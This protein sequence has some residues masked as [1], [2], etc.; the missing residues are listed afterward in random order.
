M[1][2]LTFESIPTTVDVAVEQPAA[3]Q[4]VRRQELAPADPMMEML[5]SAV[6]TGNVELVKELYA[7][8]KQVEAD[9][10]KKAFAEAFSRFKAEA[11]VIVKNVT[12]TDG[13]LKGKKHA[14]NYG[15]C[16]AV[17]PAL[18]KYGLSH[19]WKLTK[20]EPGWMEVTCTIRHVTGY[21]E[22]VSMGGAPDTGPGRNAIQARGSTKTYLERYTLLA[23][24][25]LAAQDDNDGV[26]SGKSQG[27]SDEDF[28]TRKTA[29][30]GANTNDELKKFY[31]AAVDAA[32][33][34]GDDSSVKAFANA[35][36]KRWREL[37]GGKR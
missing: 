37:N 15:V 18:S 26:G 14:D 33:K 5:A 12:I 32:K 30:E 10:A 11:V 13:P 16:S 4:Q 27:M 25:G 17:I 28:V 20:D 8:K 7:F 35:K 19:S 3:L 34:L 1:S 6:A 31:L 23:A 21:S 22:S 9:E 29:I 24:T 2:T 36:D